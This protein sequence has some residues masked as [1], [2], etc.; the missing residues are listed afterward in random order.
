MKASKFQE[1]F[2]TGVIAIV[3]ALVWSMNAKLS[4]ISES[5]NLLVYRIDE[6]KTGICD[7]KQS[8]KDVIKIQTELQKNMAVYQVDRP[9][10]LARKEDEDEE[11]IVDS[12]IIVAVNSE[13]LPLWSG[14]NSRMPVINTIFTSDGVVD[15]TSNSD[16]CGIY[17]DGGYISLEY[18]AGFKGFGC[19]LRAEHASTV[20]AKGAILSDN[21]YGAWIVSSIA[22]L[23]SSDCTNCSYSGIIA[24][25]AASIR[26]F[27]ADTTGS[28]LFQFNGDGTQGALFGISV[29]RGAI[30]SRGGALGFK[31]QP[32]GV[33]T[34]EGIIF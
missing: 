14:K 8:I 28:G 23:K 4:E 21:K 30:I 18:G 24:Y 13:W 27:K 17:A 9:N 22:D 10:I 7:N 3:V 25:D 5:M 33:L 11:V 12:T 15:L 1:L 6:N 26:A 16:Y 32:T 31:S 20:R 34:S 19:G 29:S 2:S